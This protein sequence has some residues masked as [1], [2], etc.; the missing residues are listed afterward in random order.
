MIEEPLTTPPRA[1]GPRGPGD[2]HPLETA[3]HSRHLQTQVRI[4]STA[5]CC[6]E[7]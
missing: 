3:N 7:T 5:E 2:T 1:S 4:P 6:H